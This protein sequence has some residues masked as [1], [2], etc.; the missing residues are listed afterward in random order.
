[1]I[2]L[3]TPTQQATPQQGYQPRPQQGT[4]NPP[5]REP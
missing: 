4:P 3:T 1:M 5:P 2:T